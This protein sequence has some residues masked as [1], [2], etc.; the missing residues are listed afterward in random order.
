M[1]ETYIHKIIPARKY[2]LAHIGKIKQNLAKNP[3]E[4][5]F[6]KQDAHVNFQNAFNKEK[7][8][9]KE[10]ENVSALPPGC[11]SHWLTKY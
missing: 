1:D 7:I 10:R 2:I 9:A 4:L 11:G 8:I 6:F 5:Q 3:P